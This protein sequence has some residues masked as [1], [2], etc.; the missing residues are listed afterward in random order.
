MSL[1]IVLEGIDGSG[2]S[3][4]ARKVAR[5]IE[6]RSGEVVF[7]AE[8][9]DGTHGREIRR[10]LSG[11][12]LPDPAEMSRFFIMD[13]RDD[14]KG[15]ITP[16]LERKLPVV[17]DRYY[18]SNAAYQGAMG[19]RWRDILEANRH[20]GFPE[21]DRVY[22]IDMEPEE[23]L[24]RVVGRSAQSETDLFEKKEFLDKVRF[25]YLDMADERFLTVRGTEQEEVVFQ[26]I[27]N[28]LKEIWESR[29]R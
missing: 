23:A 29:A 13:R 10:I 22:L 7:G 15:R 26:A 16:A 5:W 12:S 24:K 19:L 18:Y 27:L 1:F 11:D 8:P 20:E 28:D 6:E 21:P 14:V 2:K 3:T 17:L 9:T 4:Q 25:N